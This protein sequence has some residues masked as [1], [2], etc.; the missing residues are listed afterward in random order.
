MAV[1]PSDTLAERSAACLRAVTA[2]LPGCV[3][4][5]SPLLHYRARVVRCPEIAPISGL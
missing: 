2:K 1:F 5:Q 3:I 4:S